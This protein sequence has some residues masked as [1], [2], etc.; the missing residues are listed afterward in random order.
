MI[1]HKTIG[2]D[3][4]QTYIFD[5]TFNNYELFDIIFNLRAINIGKFLAILF[6][7]I[8]LVFFFSVVKYSNL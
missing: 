6:S 3:K 1:T 4:R 5:A 8:V 2:S 7:S